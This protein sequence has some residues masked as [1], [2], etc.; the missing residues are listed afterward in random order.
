MHQPHGV[1]GVPLR[2][3]G[4]WGE[5]FFLFGAFC[6]AH[7]TEF[8]RSAEADSE[9]IRSRELVECEVFVVWG[10]DAAS[11][12]RPLSIH[13][14][15]NEGFQ[16][17]AARSLLRLRRCVLVKQNQRGGLLSTSA[18]FELRL[19]FAKTQVLSSS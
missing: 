11:A 19:H 18:S 17:Y 9:C 16:V 10:R 6:R 2:R 1:S 12:A 4:R 15:S 5:F 13:Y 3:N 7:S 14:I 8:F